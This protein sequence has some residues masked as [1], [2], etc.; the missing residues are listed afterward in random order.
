MIDDLIFFEKEEY[1]NAKRIRSL[2]RTIEILNTQLNTAL[3]EITDLRQQ[4]YDH[5]NFQHDIEPP[6][7]F[8]IRH[9]PHIQSSDDTSSSEAILIDV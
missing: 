8:H 5:I 7:R 9:V 4:L 6:S 3:Y 2:E 1:T